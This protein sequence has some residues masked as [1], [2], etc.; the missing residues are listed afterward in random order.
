[1]ETETKKIINK[2]KIVGNIVS[3][4]DTNYGIILSCI[5]DEKKIIINLER[6]L[7][8]IVITKLEHS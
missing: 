5:E 1:M 2:D 8:K 4:N 7:S 3:V 6:N